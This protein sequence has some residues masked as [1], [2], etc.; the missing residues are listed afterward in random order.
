[1]TYFFPVY[2]TTTISFNLLHAGGSPFNLVLKT[3][4]VSFYFPSGVEIEIVGSRSYWL[5][6]ADPLAQQ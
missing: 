5:L 2:E 1:M 6:G 3:L 4:T